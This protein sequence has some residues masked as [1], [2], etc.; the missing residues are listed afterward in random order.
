MAERRASEATR[1]V[2]EQEERMP[3]R[4]PDRMPDEEEYEDERS[5][6]DSESEV[7]DSEARQDAED[8]GATEEEERGTKGLRKALDRLKQENREYRDKLREIQ[9]KD[10]SQSELIAEE[11]DDLK[12]DNERLRTYVRRAHFIEDI[13]LPRPRLAWAALQDLS[14]DVE[15]NE[16]EKTSN[17][18]EVRK[19]LRR[20]FPEEF[21]DRSVNGGETGQG[22]VG[23]DMNSRIRAAAGR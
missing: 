10:K 16:D 17:L 12:A 7:E 6:E 15:F 3:E 20:E 5:L 1:Q 19:A 23:D 13:G 21:G 11:R 4:M 2:E 14:I 9:D 22:P 18:P 8:S